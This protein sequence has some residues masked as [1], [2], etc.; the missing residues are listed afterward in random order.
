[1]AIEKLFYK[2]NEDIDTLHEKIL[3]VFNLV[4]LIDG[5]C[6][7]FELAVEDAML[8]PIIWLVIFIFIYWIEIP[9]HGC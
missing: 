6:N 9:S 7:E 5:A 4:F 8:Y 1:M 3:I 2:K